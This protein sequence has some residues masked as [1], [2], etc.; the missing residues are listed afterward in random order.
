MSN[1]Y[2]T[3]NENYIDFEREIARY[4]RFS[5]VLFM[6]DIL[7]TSQWKPHANKVSRWVNTF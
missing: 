4:C 6:I 7:V 1:A 2:D 3:Y 5:L